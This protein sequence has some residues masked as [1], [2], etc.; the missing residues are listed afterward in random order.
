MEQLRAQWMVAVADALS[1]LQAARVA[2]DAV[3]EALLASHPAPAILMRC[4]DR[5]SSS[6]VATVAQSKALSTTAKPIE[7]YT[8][9][10]LAA[11]GTRIERCF[12]QTRQ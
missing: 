5:L 7:V 10:Q 11:W 1:D 8:L 9:E 2:Q 12:P 3:L 6:L 4:W